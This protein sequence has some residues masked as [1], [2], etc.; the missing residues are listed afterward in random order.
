MSLAL[1]A[2]SSSQATS[3]LPLPLESAPYLAAL[4]ASSCRHSVSANEVVAGTHTSGPSWV[5]NVRLVGFEWLERALDD[6]EERAWCQSP[7]VSRS[8]ASPSACSRARKASCWPAR[9][10]T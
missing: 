6:I 4:V 5:K 9:N 8:W 1:R 10:V 3:T 7:L 2:S